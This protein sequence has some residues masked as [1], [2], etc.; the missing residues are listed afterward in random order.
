MNKNIFLIASLCLLSLNSMFAQEKRSS[1]KVEWKDDLSAKQ[2]PY[3]Q[4][5][6]L[7]DDRLLLFGR[8]QTSTYDPKFQ[9]NIL[10]KDLNILQSE[11]IV[12]TTYCKKCKKGK[13]IFLDDRYYLVLES[14]KLDKL[15]ILELNI[16]TLKLTDT[17]KTLKKLKSKN[18]KVIISTAGKDSKY[19]FHGYFLR[20]KGTKAGMLE[21]GIY[22]RDL[23]LLQFNQMELSGKINY[24]DFGVGSDGQF[25]LLSNRK[26]EQLKNGRPTDF[27]LYAIHFTSPDL[28]HFET[29][30]IPP[31][32]GKELGNLS[33]VAGNEDNTCLV[34]G[35]YYDDNIKRMGKASLFNPGSPKSVEK[36]G[37]PNAGRIGITFNPETD[38]PEM[39]YSRFQPE[40]LAPSFEEK[41]RHKAAQTKDRLNGIAELYNNR[42]DSLKNGNYVCLAEVY[43][44][45]SSTGV[46]IPIE[47]GVSLWVGGSSESYYGK[48]L[49]TVLSPDGQTKWE[50]SIDRIQKCANSN[51]KSDLIFR[52]QQIGIVYRDGKST[53]VNFYNIE[54]GAMIQHTIHT[55][56]RNRDAKVRP[57]KVKKINDNRFLI[58]AKRKDI[59]KFG[60]LILE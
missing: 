12:A 33:V 45:T 41:K 43:I 38:K 34:Y 35:Q 9:F 50:R 36:S 17:G 6:P 20:P 42:I 18:N 51:C 19:Y 25:W 40:V 15:T 48:I 44:P 27:Y 47:G 4:M 46:P 1:I 52:D 3:K 31:E 37:K 59:T 55:A 28:N 57:S 8:D 24:K 26:R 14:K 10:D 49:L 22:N 56:K 11:E 29:T 32:D 5:F 16:E 2:L 13:M 30:L 23:N 7:S 21:I 39:Q 58:Y 54:T 53:N 60:L